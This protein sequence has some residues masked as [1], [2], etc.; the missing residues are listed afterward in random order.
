MLFPPNETAHYSGAYVTFQPGARMAWHLHPAGQHMIVTS[1]IALT[2]TRDGKIVRF[3]AGDT[4][5]CPPDIDHWHGATS[6]A[7]MTHPVI[8]GVLD[9]QNVVWKEKVTDQQYKGKRGENYEQ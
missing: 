2:G 5:W 1:R 3:R 7:R 4:V 9:G 6:D 8:T